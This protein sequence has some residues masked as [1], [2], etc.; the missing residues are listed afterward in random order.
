[1]SNNK[2]IEKEYGMGGNI[3]MIKCHNC[4][5]EFAANERSCPYCGAENIAFTEKEFQEKIESK[6]EEIA[7]ELSK[8]QRFVAA[9]K[10]YIVL[11]IIVIVAIIAIVFAR[12]E[13]LKIQQEPTYEVSEKFIPELQ[14][15]VDN[16][17]YDK[18]A[19]IVYDNNLW[20]GKY[21]AYSQLSE[22]YDEYASLLKNEQKA[23]EN[24]SSSMTYLS[25]DT[26]VMSVSIDASYA[27]EYGLRTIWFADDILAKNT[28]YG[29]EE[30]IV[31]IRDMAYEKLTHWG[32]DK[33]TIVTLIEDLKENGSSIADD[34]SLISKCGEKAA[35]IIMNEVE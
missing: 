24:A 14:E 30:N 19:S 20:S 26:R 7:K 4:G 28:S 16:K 1:L 33:E 32:V 25:E 11:I 3:Q 9:V 34:D 15:A 6:N 27:I 13:Y 2:R 18:V 23:M 17:D 12:Y 10:K 35:E 31:E 22:V 21:V 8:P 29:T 5:A